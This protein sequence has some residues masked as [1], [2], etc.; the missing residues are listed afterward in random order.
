ME[1]ARLA[2]NPVPDAGAGLIDRS[3]SRGATLRISVP[4]TISDSCA[5]VLKIDRGLH[6]LAQ[7]EEVGVLAVAS[8]VCGLGSA[9]GCHLLLWVF[10]RGQE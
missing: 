7:F 8:L 10:D 2:E 5:R 3:L 4:T 9:R 6:R 1:R